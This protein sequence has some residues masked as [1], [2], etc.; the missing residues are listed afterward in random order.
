[1]A[2][3]AASV[4]ATADDSVPD[5]L[6]EALQHDANPVVSGWRR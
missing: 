5:T 2:L 3:E 4:D 6:L 1:M